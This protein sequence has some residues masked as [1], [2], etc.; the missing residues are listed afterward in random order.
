MNTSASGAELADRFSPVS[1]QPALDLLATTAIRVRPRPLPRQ[2]CSDADDDKFL[3]CAIAGKA[4]YVVTGDKSLLA[5]SGYRGITVL[6]PRDFV[7]RFL[8]G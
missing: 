1:L 3:S 4:K 8:T 6:T 7:D 5:T 2:V